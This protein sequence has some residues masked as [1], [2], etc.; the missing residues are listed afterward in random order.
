MPP[1]CLCRLSSQ[2]IHDTDKAA[3]QKEH[4]VDNI[5]ITTQPAVTLV[6]ALAEAL[7]I[8]DNEYR[9]IYAQVAAA[10]GSLAKIKQAL[11]SEVSF[12]WWDKWQKGEGGHLNRARKNELRVWASQHGRS[13]PPLPLSVVEAVEASCNPDAMVIHVGERVGSH[14]YIVDPDVLYSGWDLRIG[15]SGDIAVIDAHITGVRAVRDDAA[16]EGVLSLA[17]PVKRVRKPVYH[18]DLPIELPAR[19]AKLEALLAETRRKIQEGE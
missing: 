15:A 5:A 4:Q 3:Y 6:T 2:A 10:H 16:Q 9:Q 1:H 11:Q 13:L 19:L 14:V 7:D 17:L 18:V 8:S 12:G